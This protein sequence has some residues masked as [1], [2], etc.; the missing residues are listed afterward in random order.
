MMRTVRWTTMLAGVLLLACEGGGSSPKP[1]AIP[2][3]LT[4]AASAC[5][6][7]EWETVSV[8][9]I[10]PP[11]VVTGVDYAVAGAGSQVAYGHETPSEQNGAIVSA[12]SLQGARW[13]TV[14][15][16]SGEATPAT[17]GTSLDGFGATVVAPVTPTSGLFQT[18]GSGFAEILMGGTDLPSR[19][20]DIILLWVNPVLTISTKYNGESEVSWGALEEQPCPWS[21]MTCL[22]AVPMALA[23]GEIDGTLSPSEDHVGF[24]ASLTDAQREEL[25]AFDPAYGVDAQG[26]ASLASDPRFVARG[27]VQVGPDPVAPSVSWTPCDAPLS[28]AGQEPVLGE[29][30]LAPGI[31]GVVHPVLRYGVLSGSPTCS[32][33]SPGL[34]LRSQTPGCTFTADVLVDRRFGSLLI[35]PRAA[36]EACTSL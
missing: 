27:S 35:L 22:A 23:I 6:C 29:L 31:G 19:E 10:R 18:G 33:Q 7:E 34:S 14:L 32:A 11:Y 25:L 30:D 28:D 2:G 4:Q 17:I 13:R 3:C 36:A 16:R 12:D 1:C 20:H 5:T 26:L 15:L 8:D 21:P 9:V 24:L